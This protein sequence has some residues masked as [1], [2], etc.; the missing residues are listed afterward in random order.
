MKNILAA[1]AVFVFSK[2]NLFSIFFGNILGTISV[3]ILMPHELC[4]WFVGMIIGN[5][6]FLLFKFL[7]THD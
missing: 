1:I 7:I 3:L 2:E 4:D 5:L 6:I